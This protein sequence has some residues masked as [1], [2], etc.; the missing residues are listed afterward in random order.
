LAVFAVVIAA[1][2]VFPMAGNISGRDGVAVESRGEVIVNF[3]FERNAPRGWLFQ[4]LNRQQHRC[5]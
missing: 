3:F 2:V 5:H 4:F 1:G